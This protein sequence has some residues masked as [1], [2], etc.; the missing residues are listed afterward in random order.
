MK[1]PLVSII[2]PTFNRY[3]IVRETLRSILNQTYLNWECLIVDDGSSKNDFV[4]ILKFSKKDDRF[5]LLQR[6]NSRLK[7]ANACRNYGIE[8]TRGDFIIFFD[9]DD[10]M[11]ITCLE[12]RVNTFKNYKEYDFLVF[13][14][15]HFIEESNC[16]LDKNRKSINLSNKKTIE[17]FLFSSVLPWQVS[18]PIF[19]S[20]LIKN[21]ICFNENMH[22]FQ[23]DEF[24]VRV[25]ANLKLKYKSIDITDSYYRME[26]SNIKKY[27]NLIGKQ[28]ILNSYYEYTKTMFSILDSVQIL[29]N[30]NSILV[31]LF[32][33]FRS[34]I[35]KGTKLKN[36]R[37]ALNLINKKI[38]LS[39]KEFFYFYFLILL[40]KF[41]HN[42][43]GYYRTTQYIKNKIVNE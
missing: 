34:N 17:E 27:D 11:G 37:K 9:S 3:L 20:E 36:V 21:K 19:K 4:E 43:K 31:R 28:N 42:K 40:N 32:L 25:L 41:F 2:I 16:Y 10:L 29:N 8:H 1:N 22:N 30:R 5:I 13:S 18:R 24:N 14:M 26:L 15:G 12:N 6:P 35:S 23:D 38:K 33:T 7:G 39:F